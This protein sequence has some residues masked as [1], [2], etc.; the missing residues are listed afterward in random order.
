MYG[1]MTLIYTGSF[2][3]TTLRVRHVLMFEID[4]MVMPR[5]KGQGFAQLGR[6]QISF[7][8]M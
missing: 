3:S 8:S 5:A 4:L 7:V 1:H 6:G 2:V